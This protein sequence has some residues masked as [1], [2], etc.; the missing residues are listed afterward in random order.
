MLTHVFLQR[1]GEHKGENIGA[2]Y[3][4]IPVGENNQRVSRYSREIV[5]TVYEQTRRIQKLG[6]P[7]ASNMTVA[8]TCEDEFLPLTSPYGHSYLPLH[9]LASSR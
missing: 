3:H 9:R 4:Y 7:S 2:Y 6:Y 5:P 1:R 8:M